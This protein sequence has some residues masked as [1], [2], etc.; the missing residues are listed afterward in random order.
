M[1]GV[2]PGPASNQNAG[3]YGSAVNGSTSSTI[4]LGSVAY[5]EYVETANVGVSPGCDADGVEVD[6]RD[7]DVAVEDRGVDVRPTAR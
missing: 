3:A 4:P 2:V 6:R 7:D 1:S 5:G